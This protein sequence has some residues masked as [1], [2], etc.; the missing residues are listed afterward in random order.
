MGKNVFIIIITLFLTAAFSFA[1][2]AYKCEVR[3][4]ENG[5]VTLKCRRSDIKKSAVKV[6][7]KLQVKKIIEGC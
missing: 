6:G 5:K 1:A 7:D 3:E 2:Y 4:L